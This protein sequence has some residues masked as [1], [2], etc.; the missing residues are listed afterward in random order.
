[1]A[2][3]VLKLDAATLEVIGTPYGVGQT[4]Y[5]IA[6]SASGSR[7][8]V[9][10]EES[11][12]ISSI[13]TATGEIQ[14]L[15][16]E[17]ATLIGVACAPDD[18]TAYAAD[19]NNNVV[20]VIDTTST[21][22]RI[23]QAL[24]NPDVDGFGW[25]LAAARDGTQL[26]VTANSMSGPGTLVVLDTTGPNV[27]VAQ[28]LPLIDTYPNDIAVSPDSLAVYVANMTSKTIGIFTPALVRTV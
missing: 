6:V 1:M 26:F 13:E 18:R 3:Q 28:S 16:I 12:T 24:S 27:R 2:Q 23:A 22:A 19:F 7:A 21:P 17:E 9:A 15:P 25:A 20:V 5:R 4:P 8:Y 11:S 14:S 10:N